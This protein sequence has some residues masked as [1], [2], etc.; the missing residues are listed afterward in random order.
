ME[1]SVNNIIVNDFIE[2]HGI[3]NLR[4]S[5]HSLTIP[6][7]GSDFSLFWTSL[8]KDTTL[9]PDEV[10]GILVKLNLLE[11]QWCQHGVCK[12][13]S[14]KPHR[15]QDLQSYDNFQKWSSNLSS[16]ESFL[17]SQGRTTPVDY[18][19]DEEESGIE[20]CERMGITYSDD[21]SLLDSDDDF[22]TH[23]K[24]LSSPSP[25][26]SPPITTHTT[27]TTSLNTSSVSHTPPPQHTPITTN[28]TTNLS[29]NTITTSSSSSL[30]DS[31]KTN[32]HRLKLTSQSTKSSSSHPLSSCPSQTT[33]TPY[34][35]RIISKLFPLVPRFTIRI[36]TPPI[37]TSLPQ[38]ISVNTHSHNK[39]PNL[40]SSS[41]SN[42]THDSS[43]RHTPSS[44]PSFSDPNFTIKQDTLSTTPEPPTN[45]QIK[46]EHQPS[47]T[48][49]PFYNHI[50]F[51]NHK[52]VT[53]TS[54]SNT[55]VDEKPLLQQ[56]PP[57]NQVV[58]VSLS[59]LMS[60]II[61]VVNLLL[62]YLRSVGYPLQQYVFP[63]RGYRRF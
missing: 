39:S 30:P 44:H 11:N 23:T 38:P 20:W 5:D 46:I 40:T 45:Q 33:H 19:E 7:L 57:G 41:P 17:N 14:R 36:L 10:D 34:H 58:S 25:L 16:V 54:P 1:T 56:N 3:P 24:S 55:C 18:D 27:T 62:W 2:Q 22:T 53:F 59:T 28:S 15:D 32:C 12:E 4:V 29:P 13:W 60:S 6:T 52:N 61:S 43:L 47:I 51:T 8:I 31:T 35:V 26:H 42:K 63:I 50:P 9:T 49:S 21:E 37:P 48:H